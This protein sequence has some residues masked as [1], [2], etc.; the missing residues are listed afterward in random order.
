MVACTG[1]GCAESP[2]RFVINTKEEGMCRVIQN[3][4][5][6]S[7]SINRITNLIIIVLRNPDITFLENSVDL[8]QMAS[9]EAI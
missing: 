5:Q 2:D 1:G 6:F 7:Q 8:D 4:F 3:L 9:Y